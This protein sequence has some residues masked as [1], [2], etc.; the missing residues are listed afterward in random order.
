MRLKRSID[1]VTDSRHRS[2]I[3]SCI[4]DEN[5]GKPFTSS[6]LPSVAYFQVYNFWCYN[7]RPA[8]TAHRV[9]RADAYRSVGFVGQPY[10]P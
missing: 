3:R 5:H 8:S 4:Y 7:F 1:A 6:K 10:F 2:R 9:S